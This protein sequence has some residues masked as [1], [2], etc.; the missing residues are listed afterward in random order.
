ARSARCT[1]WRQ[2]SQSHT[3]GTEEEAEGKAPAPRLSTAG[4]DP[5]RQLA[6]L[7]PPRA[8]RA[9]DGAAGSST[10]GRRGRRSKSPV[11]FS[12]DYPTFDSMGGTA[13]S[14]LHLGGPALPGR[15]K[16]ER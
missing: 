10:R 7:A 16:F 9:P 2:G 5:A 4:G 13:L 8:P 3:G 1:P 6:R 15:G 14:L 11:A 12:I